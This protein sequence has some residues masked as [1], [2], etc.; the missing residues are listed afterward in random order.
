V[1][2]PSTPRAIRDRGHE[3]YDYWRYKGRGWEWFRPVLARMHPVPPVLD[4]GAGT[5]LFVECCLRSGVRA[6]GLELSQEGVA[7]MA[8]RGLPVVR[9]DLWLPFPFRDDS[10]GSALAHHV[11]E[12]VP[13]ETERAV[14]RE[15]RRVL[16][17]G[18][19]LYVISPNVHQP[20]AA[21]PDHVNLFT[22]HQLRGELRAAGFS[23]VS[24]G[25]NYWRPLWEPAL[26]LGRVG[27]LLSGALWK[28]APVDR[29]AGSASAM[30]WK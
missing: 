23:R 16:R 17:P 9:A 21:D 18:G 4:V 22:P 3:T 13:P 5:G 19:F 30:A 28:I 27:G 25:T 26:R 6:V 15:I 11:L 10:F 29:Y 7:E 14:L 12:H 2:D 8:A 1:A 20:G 24:L